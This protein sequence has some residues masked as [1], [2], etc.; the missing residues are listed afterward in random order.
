MAGC[1]AGTEGQGQQRNISS[2]SHWV[3]VM[4][5]TSRLGAKAWV[6]LISIVI[7]PQS[8][9]GISKSK[10]PYHSQSLLQLYRKAK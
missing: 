2:V 1:P 4:H 10:A 3:G 6:S 5:E 9:P 7:S 8:V